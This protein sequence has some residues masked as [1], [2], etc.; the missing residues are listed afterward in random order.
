MAYAIPPDLQGIPAWQA[1]SHRRL[2]VAMLLA[3]LFVAAGLSVLRMPVADQPIPLAELIVRLIERAADSVAEPE[4]QAEQKAEAIAESQPAPET[5]ADRQPTPIPLPDTQN[6]QPSEIDPAPLPE[7][8]PGQPAEVN[9]VPKRV[10]SSEAELFP[11]I[12]IQIVEDWREFGTEVVKEFI[13]NLPKPFTVNP[14]FDEKRRVAAIKFRPSNAPVKHEPW[15]DVEKDQIGRTIL[16]LGGGCFRVLDDPSA[17]YRDVF[18]TYT[19]FVVQCTLAFGKP[20]GREL[21]WVEEIRAKYPYLRLREE[22][23]RDPNAF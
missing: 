16:N 20:K 13:A 22:Q 5:Q 10:I 23:K 9:P 3:A 19:Q 4:A 8:A 12:E 15:D 6:V 17:V 7:T 21:P 18:E 11:P 1:S 2:K 14:I